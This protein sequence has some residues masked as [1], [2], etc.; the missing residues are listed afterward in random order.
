MPAPTADEIA[1]VD[2]S[3]QHQDILALSSQLQDALWRLDTAELESYQPLTERSAEDAVLVAGMGGSAVG[4]D[5][6]AAALGDRLTRPLITVRGYEL[7]SWATPGSVVL[8]SSYS[9]DTEETLAC[10]EAAG[11]LGAARVV[12][13]TGG[14][15]AETARADGVRVIGLPAGLLPRSAVG[16]MLVS[17]LEVAAIAGAA[18][19]LRTEIDAASSHLVELAREWAPEVEPS[20]PKQIAEQAHGASICIYG[21]GP[22]AAIAHRWKTQ[23]NEN[24]K[25]PAFSGELPEVDHNEIVGWGRAETV[26]SFLAIFLEDSDQHPRIRRR[27]ELTS[28]LI[29]PHAA[30]SIRVESR[31]KTPLE[32]L[33]SLV[34]LGD[35]VSVYLAV[36]QGV[37]PTPVDV[38]D[39]LK[40]ELGGPELD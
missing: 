20:L 35:L 3:R 6:A 12:A 33:L 11:A 25:L 7:P 40:V 14:L 38:I 32:R 5:L 36:L 2:V 13:T 9:G 24:A 34:L 10:Y 19:R 21:A 27:I 39:R 15:L 4:G 8:C 30:G 1:R 31:G 17:T 22:T 18:P 28:Q 23:V 16:Y 26:G 37:D 29:E